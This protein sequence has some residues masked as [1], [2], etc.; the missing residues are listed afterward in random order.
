MKKNE[1]KCKKMKKNAKNEKKCKKLKKHPPKLKKLE[2]VAKNSI[3]GPPKSIQKPSFPPK[4]RVFR[5]CKKCTLGFW[6]K[7][8]F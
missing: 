7:T 5:V 3:F 2:K 8:H 6:Q 4:K 1:K